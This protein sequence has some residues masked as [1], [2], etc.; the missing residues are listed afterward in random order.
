[1][2]AVRTPDRDKRNTKLCDMH[3]ASTAAPAP[4]TRT[5]TAADAL[6]ERS[7]SMT[8]QAVPYPTLI[9]NQQG[10]L[11]PARTRQGRLRPR[12]HLAAHAE[13]QFH[14]RSALLLEDQLVAQRQRYPL[15]L[16]PASQQRGTISG[17]LIA[18]IL[19]LMLTAITLTQH[20]SERM[21][22][23]TICTNKMSFSKNASRLR[24]NR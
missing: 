2:K 9:T 12:P 23:S 7:A 20:R 18:S 10:Q 15:R 4:N 5:R 24:H 3:A 11:R 1:M 17:D 21:H 8:L 14:A 19:S 6:N 22:A 13:P 16:G